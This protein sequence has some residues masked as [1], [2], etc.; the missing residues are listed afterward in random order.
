MSTFYSLY[1]EVKLNNSWY[2]VDTQTWNYRESKYQITPTYSAQSLFYEAYQKLSSD[3]YSFKQ[4]SEDSLSNTLKPH[5][6]NTDLFSFDYEEL[7]DIVLFD[8]KERFTY[9]SY[10][11]M[12]SLAEYMAND[13]ENLYPQELPFGLS[14][15][16]R[17]KL[18]KFFKWDN[19][20]DY[21]YHLKEVNKRATDRIND[22]LEVNC[23]SFHDLD[24]TRI[25]LSVC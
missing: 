6:K 1:T 14:K 16:E 23:V 5:A 17:R 10:V 9:S 2:S 12:S 7:K 20:E 8:G 24:K 13:I 19:P 11:P 21:L 25:I 22:F 15:K 18:Y 4:I 3:T